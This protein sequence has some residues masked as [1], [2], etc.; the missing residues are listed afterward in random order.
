MKRKIAL[1]SPNF[2]AKSETW[3][4]RQINYL[5][6]HISF[7]GVQQP[8]PSNHN[9]NIPVKNLLAIPNIKTRIINKIKKTP[10]NHQL[11]IEYNLN[12]L[13]KSTGF[14]TYYI[15]YLTQAYQL[16]ERLLK[17]KKDIFI[18]CH[19]YDVS[20]NFRSLEYPFDYIYD[21]DYKDF[22]RKIQN[23]AIFIANSEYTKENIKSIGISPEKIKV[24][25]FG[26]E[27]VN[28][29]EKKRSPFKILYLGRLVDCK[30]PHKTIEAFDKA[31]EL[32]MDAELII[33]GDGPLMST[34]RII[35]NKSKYSDRIK[36]LG[37]VTFEQGKKLRDECHVF[38]TH[39]MTGELTNQ[40][41]AYG[42][43]FIEALMHGMPVVTG[44]SGGIPEIVKHNEV[45]FLFEPGNIK[46]HA[47]YLFQ[48]YKD[49]NLLYSL[50][51]KSN[52]FAKYNLNTSQ[53]ISTL[54]EILK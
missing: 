48:L 11:L 2:Q 50:S 25:R 39:N 36:I 5:K 20:W 52:K 53:E 46:Q 19:G 1:L 28:P 27:I 24:L 49:K 43:S 29:K 37:P 30:G 13:E 51:N 8:V 45:G 14:N 15:H 21:E 17:T 38:T 44:D 34:I 16:K 47:K 40:I 23:K 3:I 42:V 12:N 26:T 35:K 31:C 4:W 18:H 41:E 33:A 54:N 10:Y 7:V 6:S 9:L 32:G 22:A